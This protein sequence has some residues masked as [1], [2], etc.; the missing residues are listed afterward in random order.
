MGTFFAVAIAANVLALRGAPPN[1]DEL[2]LQQG[3]CRYEVASVVSPGKNL[4][5]YRIRVWT[6]RKQTVVLNLGNE[7]S[8]A[9]RTQPLAGAN[10]QAAELLFILRL[11]A[12][13]QRLELERWVRFV[14]KDEGFLRSFN[15]VFPGTELTH[16]TL[17]NDGS[18][19]SAIGKRL[20]LGKVNGQQISLEIE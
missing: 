7:I 17:I 4:A 2:K 3:E 9:G 12:L 18:G 19:K 6:P 14:G 13:P 11:H 8:T 10:F 15:D 1:F 20:V 16:V 5:V